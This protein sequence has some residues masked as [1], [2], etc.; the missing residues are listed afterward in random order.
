MTTPILEGTDGV[1]RMGKSRGNYIGLTEP[2]AEQFGKLMS[3]PDAAI[4]RYAQL[5]A[6]WPEA[7]SGRSARRALEWRRPSDGR[8]E[9]LG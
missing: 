8:E 4:P 3:I 5:A 2:A 7:R 1:V 9:R 6:F